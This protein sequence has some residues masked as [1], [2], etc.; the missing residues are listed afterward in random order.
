MLLVSLAIVSAASVISASSLHSE[1]DEPSF[2]E[3]VFYSDSPEEGYMAAFEPHGKRQTG[4][5]KASSDGSWS[6]E[7]FWKYDNEDFGKL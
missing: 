6:F 4:E 2:Y 3:E 7:P 5:D 1:K